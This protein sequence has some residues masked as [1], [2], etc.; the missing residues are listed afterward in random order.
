MDD[1][2]V[3]SELADRC[4]SRDLIV[5]EDEL[6]AAAHLPVPPG[7]TT[8]YLGHLLV[9]P[10]R[11]V[12]APSALSDAEAARL[13]RLIARLSGVLEVGLGAEHVYILRLGH[14]WEHFHIH[15]VARHPGTPEQYRG[16]EV[17]DWHGAPM[18]D[19][20]RLAASVAAMRRL[21]EAR[22]A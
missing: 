6:F 1:C 11:H 20:A 17:E 2:A 13:G 16:L 15:L 3:C 22:P 19:H 9:V 4:R 10:R 12:C 21:V 18:A 14:S 8:T 7:E 5:L